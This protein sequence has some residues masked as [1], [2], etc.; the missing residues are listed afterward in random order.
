MSWPKAYN[1]ARL[2]HVPDDFAQVAPTLR[3]VGCMRHYKID[4]RILYR[5]EAQSGVRC[6]R[7]PIARAEPEPV[8]LP[9]MRF[10]LEDWLEARLR[11]QR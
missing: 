10:A 1:E 3:V 11:A 4:S 2:R 6:S 9:P 7:K 5:W 8:A